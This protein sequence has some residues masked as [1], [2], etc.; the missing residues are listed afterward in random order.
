MTGHNATSYSDIQSYGRCPAAYRWRKVVRIQRKRKNKQLRQGSLMHDGLKEFFLALRDDMSFEDAFT[1][2]GLWFN[3][4][5]DN[6]WEENP[7]LFQDEADE[8]AEMIEES[9]DIVLRYLLSAEH[10]IMTWE[11]LH[12]EEEFLMFIDNG[13]VTFTPDLIIRDQNDF[14][15]IIDHKSTASIPTGGVPFSDLQTLTYYSGIKDMYPELRGFVFNYLRKATPAVPRLNKTHNTASKI[16][17]HHFVNNLKSIDTTYEI[18]LDFLS[19]EAPDLLG[20][21]THQLRL[22]ELRETNRFFF[23][24]T[25]VVN[26]DT[27][28]VMIDELRMSLQNM[29]HSRDNDTYPR[30][31][32]KFGVQSCDR[33]E[34]QRICHTQLLGWNEEL[35]LEEDYEPREEKNP[36]ESDEE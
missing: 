4:R 12:V 30:V 6:A 2:T 24:E 9:Q 3:N 22:A 36:Y 10:E 5:M 14:V 28:N 32:A 13:V 21:P 20:E 8:L 7:H 23:T 33:C 35:V 31:F 16:F 19:T 34:F 17:G 29:Q 26:D 1:T 27:V 25:I 15:W 18:L 11:I